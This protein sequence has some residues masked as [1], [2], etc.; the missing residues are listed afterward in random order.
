MKKNDC[1]SRYP[2]RRVDIDR[3]LGKTLR[4]FSHGWVRTIPVMWPTVYFKYF[5][6]L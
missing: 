4:G 1:I 5:N 2:R 3:H 6:I